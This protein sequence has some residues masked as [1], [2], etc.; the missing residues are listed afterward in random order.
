MTSTITIDGVTLNGPA[1]VVV[2]QLL[3]VQSIIKSGA[4]ELL[5]TDG[6]DDSGQ[7]QRVGVLVKPT[8]SVSIRLQNDITPGSLEAIDHYKPNTGELFEKYNPGWDDPQHD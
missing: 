3:T 7:P 5:I 4:T 2:D 6:T 8:S 1:V